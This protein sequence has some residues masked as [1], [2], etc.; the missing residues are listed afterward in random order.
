MT[1]TVRP[2]KPKLCPSSSA[3]YRKCLLTPDWGARRSLC[4]FQ[5]VH[6]AHREYHVM[7]SCRRVANLGRGRGSRGVSHLQICQRVLWPH[8]ARV[9]KFLTESSPG[10]DNAAHTAPSTPQRARLKNDR[11]SAELATEGSKADRPDRAPATSAMDAGRLRSRPRAR[12]RRAPVRTVRGNVGVTAS[13][14]DDPSWPDRCY[15]CYY[16]YQH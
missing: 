5:E 15:R 13:G 1:D 8:G 16:C 7:G 9:C 10:K 11:D 6:G 12:A 3:L 14:A 2:E 4:C